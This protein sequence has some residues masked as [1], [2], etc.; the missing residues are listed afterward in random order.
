MGQIFPINVNNYANS[1]KKVPSMKDNM[2]KATALKL[3]KKVYHHENTDFESLYLGEIGRKTEFLTASEKALLEK[4]NLKPNNFERCSHNELVARFQTVKSDQ[5][6]SLKFVASLFLKGLSGEVPR[7]RQTLM[8][9]W[10]LSQ[11]TAHDFVASPTSINCAIC[12]LP[13]EVIH[14][15]TQNLYTYYLG[16]SW[17]EHPAK[18]V[19]ELEDI[20]NYPEPMVKESDRKRLVALLT[21]IRRA[22]KDET[23][24]QLEKRI[25]KAKVLPKTDKYKRYGILQTLAVTGILPSDPS[26]DKQP[27][28]SDIVLPLAGWRGE[29]GIDENRVAQIF[30]IEIPPESTP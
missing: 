1:E 7:F 24:G 2:S 30:G 25:A 14:D 22:D 4:E 17:N 5:R 8:S 19:C 3:L 20:L 18:F 16:H 9:Y 26:K 12:S 28:K 23:P 29:L 21:A 15:T 6:L 27:S 11:L 10:Y 13:N